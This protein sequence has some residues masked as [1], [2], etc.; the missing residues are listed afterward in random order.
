MP[1]TFIANDEVI[2][3]DVQWP[4]RAGIF[5]GHTVDWGNGQPIIQCASEQNPPVFNDANLSQDH[6]LSASGTELLG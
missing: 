4:L 2:P 5:Y 1:G 6:T 3:Q